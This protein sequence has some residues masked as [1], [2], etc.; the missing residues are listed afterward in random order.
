LVSRLTKNITILFDGDAAG[1]RASLRG[2]DLILEQGMNVKVV[3]FPDG[4]DPDSYAK[5]VSNTEL[6][7]YLEENSQDFI[8]FKVALL[9][10]ETQNDPVKKAGLIRDIVVSISKIPDRIQREVYIQEC[11]RI[12]GISENVLYS[13]LA[14]LSKKELRDA[15][16][17]PYTAIDATP[18]LQ[19]TKKF[20]EVDELKKYE[21]EIIKILLL[22]G[23][24]KID[25]VDYKEG[26]TQDEFDAKKQEKV[27]YSNLVSE[28]IYLSLQED[29][30]EFTDE[31]FKLLYYEVIHQLNQHKT[32]SIDEFVNHKNIEV[33]NLV[34][35]I[36]MDDEKYFTSDWSKREIVVK[37]RQNEAEISKMVTDVIYNLRRILIKLKISALMQELKEGKTLNDLDLITD[38]SELKV[39]IA[40][41]LTRVV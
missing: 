5:K 14:Q 4:E 16:K 21:R 25:F 2:I 36:L 17:K 34:T 22:Y 26:A 18:K 13:E 1:I 15:S 32:I 6:K 38:Y 35:N 12:M 9:T 37:G 40:N 29:E 19:K 10:E 27:E 28:E 31:L 30:V 20:E 33:S 24:K 11:S 7:Q 39:K 23:N 3:L 8:N 41:K